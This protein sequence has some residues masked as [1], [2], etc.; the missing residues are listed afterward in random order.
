[1][2]TSIPPQVASLDHTAQLPPWGQRGSS[3]WS[4]SSHPTWSE[5]LKS[6]SCWSCFSPLS[7][8]VEPLI[9]GPHV[10]LITLVIPI[11]WVKVHGQILFPSCYDS[12][13]NFL[14]P[15]SV[16]LNMYDTWAAFLGGLAS[17]RDLPTS[18]VAVA[19]LCAFSLWF[20]AKKT[21]R[22]SI[23]EF[24]HVPNFPFSQSIHVANLSVAP[25][26]LQRSWK[27]L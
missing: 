18:S 7:L 9:T 5:F 22:D 25:N 26:F 19:V 12:R 13:V 17:G 27:L 10:P 24:A 3:M 4:C 8:S 6:A 1:M 16:V 23:C 21:W 2:H 15:A 20:F 11:S 14:K